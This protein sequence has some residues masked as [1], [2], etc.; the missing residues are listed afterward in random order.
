MK[1]FIKKTLAVLLSATLLF[2]VVPLAAA[3][4]ETT[5]Q[6]SVGA[7]SGTT[8]E[9]TWT[10]D[11]N[12][13]L[14][15]SGNGEMRNYD[16]YYY[17]HPW[18]DNITSVIINDGVTSIGGCAFYG[19]T[20]LTSVTIGDSVTYIGS[21]AF[22]G[23]TNLT[24]LTFPNS[25]TSI[26]KEAF[27]GCANLKSIIIPDGVTSI[28]YRAFYGCSDLERLY[29]S[30]TVKEIGEC[31]FGCC[32][33]LS[34]IQVDIDNIRFD[35]RDNCNSVIEHRKNILLIGCK[36]TTIPYSVTGIGSS[37]FY[38]CTGLTSIAIPNSITSIGVSAFYGCTGLLSINIPDSITS[39]ED[40][41]FCGCAGLNGIDIPNSIQSIGACAFKGCENI[42]SLYIP[43]SVTQIGSNAFCDCKGITSVNIPRSVSTKMG[44]AAFYGCTG[45]LKVSLSI[46][47]GPRSSFGSYFGMCPNLDTVFID[48]PT[49]GNNAFEG[50]KQLKH[51]IFGDSV[52]RIEDAAFYGCTGL[53][54]IE[55]PNTLKSIGRH[56]FSGCRGLTSLE[57]P[58]SV[59][60]IGQ[61]AFYGCSGLKSVTMTQY[62]IDHSRTIFCQY[63]S[64]FEMTNYI[65][66]A[67]IKDNVTKIANCAF[68]DWSYL[69]NITIPDS[70]TS[71]GKEAFCNCSGLTSVSLPDSVKEIGEF[72]FY[73]CMGIKSITIPDS[74]TNIGNDAIGYH[75]TA[76]KTSI[77]SI[78]G[79]K[80]FGYKESEAEKYGWY[81]YIDFI[82]LTSKT[83]ET[84][85]IVFTD[86][87]E[88]GIIRVDVLT[89]QESSEAAEG[90]PDDVSAI[91]VYDIADAKAGS[92]EQCDNSIK[93]MIPCEKPD[94][95]VFCKEADGSNTEM[96]AVYNDGY[97]VFR[98]NR[99]SVFIVT[100]PYETPLL[101]IGDIDGNRSI[102]ISDVTEIQRYIAELID[103]S[104]EQLLLADTNGD[105]K[106]DIGD[107]THLQKYLAEFDVV[108]GKQTKQTTA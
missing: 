53:Q 66:T 11:D 90:L 17:T 72:A 40:Y 60:S 105:S 68:K 4:A 95:K 19:C 96:H 29:I 104:N 99:F 54:N 22:Q 103:F 102:T 34:K 100:I 57:I 97:L 71:I 44:S 78:D 80:I 16:D 8:G 45:L 75:G 26:E 67:I 5:V 3:A 101:T 94:G 81:N 74:V 13:V 91:A 48:Y 20:G 7:S 93:I 38:G 85:G 56:A 14:T 88:N 87:P 15:I 2:S 77:E 43:N 63:T 46:Y 31:A 51:I 98:T 55:F 32:G 47:L 27:E 62:M 33:N 76:E 25:I 86:I 69:K 84:S 108:L 12:G 73:N 41:A 9:C 21:G 24:N 35:S 59:E 18:G 30:A 61:E 82:P 58:D 70:V 37:A 28:G 42:K 50:Y 64:T 106:V 23:C 10:L 65:E 49:I 39:I 6:E 79:F 52:K 92:T 36:S 89:G 1:S 107:A 83:D